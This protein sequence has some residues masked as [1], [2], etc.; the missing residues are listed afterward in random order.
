MIN[1]KVTTVAYH[2]ILKMKQ[3]NEYEL[4]G[5]TFSFNL[6]MSTSKMDQRCRKN[7]VYVVPL[8]QGT[9]VYW[10]VTV[11]LFHGQICVIP[12]LFHYK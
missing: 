4:K 12:T 8:F 10:Y 3:N 9:G 6:S 1:A 7:Y 2:T 5:W 11:Q